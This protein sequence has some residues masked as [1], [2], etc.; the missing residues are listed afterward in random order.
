MYVCL[1]VEVNGQVQFVETTNQDLVGIC[2]TGD[3]GYL[4]DALTTVS[5]V[6]AGYD[7]INN[8]DFPNSTISLHLPGF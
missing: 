8:R 4:P 6:I 1:C 3:S 5:E 2:R 7:Y